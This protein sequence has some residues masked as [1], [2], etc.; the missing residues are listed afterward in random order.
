METL[1]LTILPVVDWTTGLL[2]SLGM[3]SVSLRTALGTSTLGGL[4]L[5][6]RI[7]GDG[8]DDKLVPSGVVWMQGES[9]ADV[10]EEIAER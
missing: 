2:C 6:F 5:N 7:D 3:A 1:C 4:A 8:P 9:D 10:T